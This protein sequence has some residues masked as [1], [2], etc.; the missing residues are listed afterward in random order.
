[1]S[2]IEQE[3]TIETIPLSYDSLQAIICTSLIKI[4][5]A[6]TLEVHVM[7]VMYQSS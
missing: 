6:T 7:P 3:R 2:E 1:M 5:C 4:H